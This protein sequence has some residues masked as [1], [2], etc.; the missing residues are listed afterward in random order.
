MN[1]HSLR[2]KTSGHIVLQKS[3]NVQ[4]EVFSDVEV[5]QHNLQQ[6]SSLELFCASYSIRFDEAKKS[7]G[8]YEA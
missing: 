4:V 1:A 8:G 3:T 2:A 6:Q 5:F 7:S